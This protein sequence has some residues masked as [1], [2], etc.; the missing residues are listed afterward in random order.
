MLE[1]A[2]SFSSSYGN[3]IFSHYFNKKSLQSDQHLLLKLQYSKRIM[4]IYMSSLLYDASVPWKVAMPV[5]E[6]VA[7][8]VFNKPTVAIKR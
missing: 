6:S 1:N 4:Q 3:P 2:G 5:Q 7:V 8:L